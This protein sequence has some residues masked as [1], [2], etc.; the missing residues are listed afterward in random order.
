M[1]NKLAKRGK[2]K[3][4][5]KKQRDYD[6][7]QNALEKL[8]AVL[9]INTINQLLIFLKMNFVHGW[10]LHYEKRINYNIL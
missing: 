9:F 10:V 2:L 1:C 4:H 3:Y 6:S 5:I 7:S 8:L